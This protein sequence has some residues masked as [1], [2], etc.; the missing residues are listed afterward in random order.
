MNLRI[1]FI[2]LLTCSSCS[3]KPPEFK[4]IKTKVKKVEKPFVIIVP[5][6]NNQDWYHHNLKS[7][8]LQKYTNY[9]VLYFDDNSTDQTGNLVEKFIKQKKIKQITFIK[10]NKRCGALANLWQG[11][12]LA[13]DNEIIINLDGDDWFAHDQVLNELNT[14]YQSSEVWLTYGQFQN[15]PTKKM[16]WCKEIPEKIIQ[17]NQFRQYGFWFAQPRTYY[18]WLAKKIKKENL[19]D[20]KTKNFYMVA[21]DVALMFPLVEMAGTHIKFIP[22]ILCYRNVKTPLNDFK[23]NLKE[24][25]KTTQK[26]SSLKP[27]Q[28]LISSILESS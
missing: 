21:G 7:I 13:E 4:R 15:W 18:A 16:G 24:Q 2:I 9:R 23:C 12:Q 8:L 3:H 17:H 26:I 6:Y 28:K 25:L 10:N 19:I 22:N 1:F 27:Y 11:I 14:I 5:S 20:Q